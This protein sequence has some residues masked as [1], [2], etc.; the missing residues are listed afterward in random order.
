MFDG[1]PEETSFPAVG[2]RL[3]AFQ[4]LAQLGQGARG[5]VFLAAQSFLADRQVVVKLTPSDGREHL[6]LARLQ[7]THIVPLYSIEEDAERRLRALCMPF[8]GGASL[9]QLLEGMRSLPVRERT[10]RDLLEILDRPVQE[11]STPDT[12]GPLGEG[13]RRRGPNPSRRLLSESSYADAICWMGACLA[14]A[15]AYAHER[16]L[17]HLDLKP[18]NILVT[19]DGKPMLLDF[20]LAHEPIRAGGPIPEWLGGTP[21]YMS[22]EQERALEAVRRRQ[23]VTQPVDGRSD[24]YSLGLVLYEALAGD[25]PKRLKPPL[26]SWNPAVPV[27]LSDVIGECVRRD[28]RNR[29]P[30][31]RDLADDLRRHLD[32]YPL[33]GVRNRS[34]S[35]RWRKW[36]QRRPHALRVATLAVLALF[37][38]AAAAAVA[39]WHLDVET[40]Q[41]QTALADA[42][43]ALA[44]RR[45]QTALEACD[46]GIG[47]ANQLFDN[48]L[49]LA[50]Q[51]SRLEAR[52]GQAV[53]DLHQV[54]DRLRFHY[55]TPLLS[56]AEQQHLD[57]A[58]RRVWQQ[59]ASLGQLLPRADDQVHLPDLAKDL[60]DVVILWADLRVRNAPEDRRHQERRQAVALLEE[61]QR[62]FGQSAILDYFRRRHAALAPEGVPL[63]GGDQLARFTAW[64]HYALGRALLA[65]R[66]FGTADWEFRQALVSEPRGLWPNFY[67]G[68]CCYRLGQFEESALAF[69]TCLPL[70]SDPAQCFY[71]RALALA[72]AGNNDKALA[73]LDSCLKFSP[74]LGVAWFERGKLNYRLKRFPA[75]I[76]DFGQAL[77]RGAE[78]GEVHYCLARVQLARGDRPRAYESAQ[79]ALRYAPGDADIR[80]FVAQLQ[81]GR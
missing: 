31:A 40:K 4:L 65:D 33:R 10:G 25:V 20:H 64:E 23:T 55:A 5:R 21:G 56:S 14:D 63:P 43:Q 68:V 53:E 13:G 3:G 1:L 15:L 28:P 46:R 37:A 48:R 6:S 22:P 11:A 45:F 9:A 72:G 19:A 81:A 59:R 44:E 2:E 8:F 69:S 75:A 80:A 70:A 7:H 51:E 50:L 38:L 61:A 16:G 62:Q 35:E 58:C 49:S 26:R 34:L 67:H 76:H 30:S 24:I 73:D 18:S 17:V 78:P 79:Q 60:L 32:H 27:G 39:F 12:E 29:Y 66:R 57:N 36:R 71:N 42:R 47:I 41:A 52:R 77:D 74:R 54:A